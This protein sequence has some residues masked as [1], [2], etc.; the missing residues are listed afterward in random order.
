M[1]A[2]RSYYEFGLP[3]ARAANTGISGMIDAK[4]RVLATL[5]MGREGVLDVPLP[6]ALAPTPYARFGDAPILALIL[7][8]SIIIYRL[9]QRYRV[10][11]GVV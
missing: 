10:D 1:Y 6:A 2:I 9:R 7:T 11:P 4:G 3:L 8:L 5:G